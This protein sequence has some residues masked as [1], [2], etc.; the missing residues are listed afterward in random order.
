MAE[1]D[2]CDVSFDIPEQNCPDDDIDAVALFADI[3]FT[4][5]AA[6]AARKA[7]WEALFASVDDDEVGAAREARSVTP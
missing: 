2:A 3:D 6:V 1:L 7:E 4:D 5:P